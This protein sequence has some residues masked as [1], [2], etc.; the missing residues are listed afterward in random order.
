[1]E[2]VFVL[3]A[4]LHFLKLC[5]QKDFFEVA[6]KFVKTKTVPQAVQLE[7]YAL[8][9]LA[10]VGTAVEKGSKPG[11]LDFVEK[12]KFQAW[13]DLGDVG[14]DEARA[15]YVAV[16]DRIFGDWRA[17]SSMGSTSLKDVFQSSEAREA[18]SKKHAFWDNQPMP[19]KFNEPVAD[20]PVL[21][22]ID[23]QIAVNVSPDPLPLDESLGLEWCDDY[24]SDESLETI[25]QVSVQLFEIFFVFLKQCLL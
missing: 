12:A 21:E 20:A 14:T 9:K 16:I 4:V 24:W 6:C 2:K 11:W 17:A 5:F 23:N 19:N 7:L 13:S 1:M 10:T 3:G 18:A 8:F 15:R 22:M 25:C